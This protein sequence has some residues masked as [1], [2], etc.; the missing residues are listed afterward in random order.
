MSI[1]LVEARDNE[2]QLVPQKSVAR[3]R[4]LEQWAAEVDVE[5]TCDH[6]ECGEVFPY[7]MYAEHK[8]T[9]V[10][11]CVR[12]PFAGCTSVLRCG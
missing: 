8:K 9:C 3:A 2:G 11:C 1:N 6:E 5:V 10:G 12:C 7:S 4:N